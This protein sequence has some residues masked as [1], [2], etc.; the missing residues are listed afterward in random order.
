MAESLS[1]NSCLWHRDAAAQRKRR[2]NL[3][4]LSFSL[5][6]SL[7]LRDLAAELAIFKAAA[8]YR[9]LLSGSVWPNCWRRFSGNAAG[10]LH[11]LRERRLQRVHLSA[12]ASPISLAQ[13]V[14][15]SIVMIVGGD[16]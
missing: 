12:I 15:R 16:D 5:C 9:T 6:V 3:Y 1:G 7:R 8:S 14:L 13:E 10:D 11:K 2:G 4:S